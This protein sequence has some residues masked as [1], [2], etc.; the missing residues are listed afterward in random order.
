MG[1]KPYSPASGS[2]PRRRVHDAVYPD[3]ELPQLVR[4]TVGPLKLWVCGGW[5]GGGGYFFVCAFRNM[6]D[7]KSGRFSFVGIHKDVAE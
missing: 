5:E 3:L 1:I 2:I 6:E 4:R 7:L